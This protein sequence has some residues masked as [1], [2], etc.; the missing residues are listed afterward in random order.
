MKRK[1]RNDENGQR[2]SVRRRKEEGG[3]DGFFEERKVGLGFFGIADEGVDE[4]AV[5]DE[6]EVG[7][8]WANAHGE[9]G[10]SSL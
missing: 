3:E 5:G 2:V 10:E 9:F 1:R 6:A 8:G 7:P 4:A